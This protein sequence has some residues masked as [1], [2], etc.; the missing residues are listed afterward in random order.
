MH[1]VLRESSVEDSQL[2]MRS[3]GLCKSTRSA[4]PPLREELR[5]HAAILLLGQAIDERI[6]RLRDEA[7]SLQ[8]VPRFEGQLLSSQACFCATS[9]H[10]PSPVVR[11]MHKSALQDIVIMLC[12]L[13]SMEARGCQVSGTSEL[14]EELSRRLRDRELRISEDQTTWVRFI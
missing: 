3:L 7:S 9:I 12:A 6:Q 1:Q 4:E 2:V 11:H 13:E 8:H 10:C 14:A 5:S